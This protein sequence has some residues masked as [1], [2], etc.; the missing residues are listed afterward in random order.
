MKVEQK[1][2]KQISFT[3]KGTAPSR[4][5]V[6]LGSEDLQHRFLLSELRGRSVFSHSDWPA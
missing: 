1:Q 6:T 4:S 3:W 2:P 5:L